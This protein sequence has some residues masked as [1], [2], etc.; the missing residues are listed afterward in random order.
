MAPPG[1]QDLL[2]VSIFPRLSSPHSPMPSLNILDNIYFE[3]TAQEIQD[4]P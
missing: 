3:L 4:L 1:I 2:A